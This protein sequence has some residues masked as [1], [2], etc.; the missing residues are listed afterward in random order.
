MKTQMRISVLGRVTFALLLG[1]LL[2][3]VGGWNPA[4]LQAAPVTGAGWLPFG[5]RTGAE[6]PE[7][8]L[9]QADLRHLELSADLPG[10]QFETVTVNGTAYTRLS[11][12]GYSHFA[13][14]GAPDLPVLRQEVE[15]PW[16][17]SVKVEVLDS[18]MTEST[19]NELKLERLYPRQAPAVKLPGGTPPFALDQQIYARAGFAP[20]ALI[21]VGQPYVVRGHRLVS[22]EVRPVAY[23][24]AAGKV[25]F[26]QQVHFRLQ[27]SGSNVAVSLSNRTK[28]ASPLFDNSLAPQVLNYN[29]GQATPKTTALGYLIIVAD[30]YYDALQPFVQLQQA[31]GFDVT[32]TKLSQL[33]GSTKEQIKTYIQTAYDSWSVRPSYVLLVG[34]TD[35]IPAW[36]SVESSGKYTDLYYYT[37]DGTSDWHPDVGRGR[38]PVRSAAQTTAMVN[39]YVAYAQLVGTEPWLKKAAFIATC[40]NYQVAEPTHNYVISTHTGPKGYTGIFPSDPQVGG[41]KIY[42]VGTNGT[43]TNITNA[44]NDG[45]WAI[46]YSGHGSETGWADGNVSYS[47]AQVQALNATG[48]TPFVASHACVTGSFNQ[49]ECYAETWVLQENKGALVMW[50]SSHNTYWD[51][52]DVLEKKMFDSLFVAGVEHPD[53]AAMTDFGLRAVE[54]AYSDS[55]RYYWEAYQVFGDPSVRIF[56]DPERPSFAL[57]VTPSQLSICNS[58]V[59]TTSVR[60][61]SLR[62]YSSTVELTVGPLPAGITA[63]IVPASFQAPFTATLTLNVSPAVAGGDYTLT[64]TATD[65]VSLTQTG[66][67]H[68]RVAKVSPTAP[69]LITPT[70]GM[71][72]TAFAPAFQWG[73]VALADQYRFRLARTPFFAPTVVDV[74]NLSG[75]DYTSSTILESGRCYW[76]QAQSSNICGAG[77]W[78]EPWHFAVMSRANLFI[79]DMEAG[80]GKWSHQA[81]SGTDRWAI[82]S[83][84]SHGGANAWLVPDD[85]TVTDSRLWTTT[86]ITLDNNSELTFWHKYAFE[87]TS[88]GYDGAVL[89]ISTDGGSSWIDLGPRITSGGYNGTV[90]SAYNNPLGGRNAWI[91][92]L[93]TWTKVTVDLSSYGGQ[94][95]LLRWRLGCDSST[96][97]TGWFIDDVAISAP[98]ALAAPATVESVAPGGALSTA[99]TTLTITG[100]GFSEVPALK[101][102]NTWLS[103]TLVNSTTLTA[104]VPAGMAGG[105]YALTIYNGDCQPTVVQNAFTVSEV[106]AP[107]TGVS[108]WS[109][110]V[111]SLGQETSFSATITAGSPVTYTWAFGDGETGVGGVVKH[112]Y[113]VAGNYTAMVTASN[114]LGAVTA[115]TSVSVRGNIFTYLPI[116][117]RTK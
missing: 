27:L 70:E 25:R 107:I 52:D 78:A 4:A 94:A 98:M 62:D 82:V 21:V 58:G 79:D 102:G 73:A 37:M 96:G 26:Y 41:D 49:T 38:F 113:L 48:V 84:S 67:I 7:M 22:V 60:I 12:D 23:D 5:E 13:A 50:A 46:I 51:E 87:G 15:I 77:D 53:V 2:S 85:A 114:S 111:T 19:L 35:T 71:T 63:G 39:K 116:V 14:V 108:A 88:T 65:H 28:Y 10:C 80:A 83:T 33:P 45:R 72:N 31:R 34:D 30:A 115:T 61:E 81:A 29:L 64:V 6:T 36:S 24:P 47:Q 100:T 16:G 18:K 74:S 68:L 93:V 1:L 90:S 91:T 42:C 66:L 104:I 97:D 9:L 56:L 103:S 44:A 11:G 99:V 20:D 106:L 117:V 86:P 109:S 40:D 32:V 95:V 105:A 101:L 69:V 17:A 55:A 112:R 54:T 92:D 76:W 89:E 8:N 57:S 110:G 59:L 75:L 3:G 43:A